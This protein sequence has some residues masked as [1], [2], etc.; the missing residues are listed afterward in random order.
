MLPTRRQDID[1]LRVLLFGT[2]ILYHVGMLYVADWG[3]HLKS[4]Y[5]SETLQIPMLLVNRWRMPLLFLISGLALNFLRRSLSAPALLRN[6]T[7]RV[8]LPLLFGMAVVV[9]IQPYCQGVANHLVEP[10]F[11]RFLLRYFSGGP[12]PKDAFDGWQYGFTWNHLWYLAYLWVYALQL[13]LLLPLLESRAGLALRRAVT[14]LRGG[15]LLVLPAIPK[16]LALMLLSDDFPNTKNLIRDWYQHALYFS[17]FLL[18]WWLATDHGLWAELRALRHRTL[19]FAVLNGIAY[20]LIITKLL[21][22]DAGG[23]M[24]FCTRI[25]SGLNTW[26][27]IATVLGWSATWLDRPF[28]WLPYAS[29]AVLPWYI[30]HQSLIVAVASVLVPMKIGPVLEPLTVIVFTVLGCALLHEFAIRRSRLLRLCFGLRPLP[31][32]AEQ[33]ETAGASLPPA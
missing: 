27:W 13:V 5:L 3:W 10:G 2:L 4:S 15:A 32:A 8:L 20:L 11:G 14:G 24:L 7:R 18:G 25:L 22:D 21:P 16:M 19:G 28:R 17:Y 29:E 1:A 33:R 30:L 26:F 23:W 31:R 9:P 12:W 6:R